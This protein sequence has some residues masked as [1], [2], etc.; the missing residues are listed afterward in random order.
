MEA[1]DQ[2]ATKI[3]ICGWREL[4]PQDAGEGGDRRYCAAPEYER[5]L[6]QI[7]LHVGDLSRESHF[8]CCH[9]LTEFGELGAQVQSLRTLLFEPR[10]QV[11]SRI[12]PEG[13]AQLS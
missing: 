10:Y 8:H 13:L 7:A 11:P 6:H 2:V 12:F 9:L 4:L 3:P 1:R 5:P